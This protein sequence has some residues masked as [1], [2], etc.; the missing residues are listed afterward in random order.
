MRRAS[1]VFV[2]LATLAISAPAGVAEAATTVPRPPTRTGTRA[3]ATAVAPTTTVPVP[4]P[5]ASP[6]PTVPLATTTPSTTIVGGSDSTLEPCPD[7]DP[8]AAVF[9]GEV[10]ARGD[11]TATFAVTEMRQGTLPTKTIDVDYPDDARFLHIGQ[12]YLVSASADPESQRLMSKIRRPRNEGLTPA[13]TAKDLV[14]T[15]K[16][17][18][19]KID[20]GV[21]AGMH[22]RWGS[23]LLRILLPAAVAFAVLLA[24]VLV[25]RVL[26]FGF[27]LP[28]RLQ[29]WRRRRRGL[30]A[31]PGLPPPVAPTARKTRTRSAVPARR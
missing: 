7:F 25:K 21:F 16:A 30:P 12:R 27:R 15:K 13:C 9:V 19:T 26:L 8:P 20:T 17:D 14:V 4:P 24:L 5:P 2:V 29:A 18:G 1:A 31:R 3:A 28:A 22:G 10:T 11:V 6:V 23:V